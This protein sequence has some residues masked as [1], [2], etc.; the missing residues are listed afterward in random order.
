MH[1]RSNPSNLHSSA[2][3][4]DEIQPVIVEEE[5]VVGEGG[6][7]D[8]DLAQVVQILQHWNLKKGW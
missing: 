3:Y 6:H 7:G 8:T 2:G 5:R 4:S 1:I